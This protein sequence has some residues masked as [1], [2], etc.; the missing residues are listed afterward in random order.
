MVPILLVFRTPPPTSEKL[1]ISVRIEELEAQLASAL[2]AAAAAKATK[3]KAGQRE[4]GQM[5]A[6]TRKQL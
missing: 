2:H 6:A 3:D 4:A 1:P 5:V